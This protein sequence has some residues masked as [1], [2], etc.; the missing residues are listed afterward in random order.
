[1]TQITQTTCALNKKNWHQILFFGLWRPKVYERPPYYKIY[2]LDKR[3]Q[4]QI[5]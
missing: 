4:L 1:M 3:Y 2:T 5:A